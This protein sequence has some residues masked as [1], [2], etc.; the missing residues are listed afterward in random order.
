MRRL[1]WL[2][3]FS[4]AL[5]VLPLAQQRSIDDFFRQFSDE[6]VRMNPNLAVA[7]RYFTG[8]EQNQLEQQITPYT[9]G[10]TAKRRALAR[11]GIA[12]LTRF[13]RVRLT[14]VQRLSADLLKYQLQTYVGGERYDHF[15]FPLEQFDGA[16]ISLVTSLTVQHPM[17]A[18]RD[19]TNYVIRL[20]QVG[21]RMAEAIIDCRER[22]GGGLIPPRFI[23]Q[24]TITQMRRFVEVPVAENPFV[25][26]F[27]ERAMTISDL[28]SADRASLVAQA[29]QIVTTDVYPRWKEA[30]AFLE[31]LVPRSAD[32]AGLWRFEGG[33]EA[34]RY[35]LA[36]ST[37][38]NLTADQI[39]D[40][41]L[42]QV[43]R[44]EREMDALLQRLGRRD[45]S[46][47]ARVAQL[48]KDLGYPLTEDGRKQ[49]MADIDAMIAEAQ[50][51]SA[52]QFDRRPQ[53]PVIAQP[54]PRFREANAAAS[55]ASP[56]LDGSRPAIFQIP[57]RPERMT[58][59]GLRTLVHH[60]TVPG[61]HF[62]IALMVED[63]S[64]P[65]F[66]QARV[67][68]GIPAIT[69]GWALYA[70]RLAG[71][72]GW[73]ADDP[74]GLL[75]QMDGELFRARRLVVDTG[76]HAKRWTRQQAIDYGIEA[77]EVERYVVNPGQACAYMIGQLKILELRDRAKTTLKDRFNERAFH[78]AV[79]A[80]GTVPLELLEQEVNRYIRAA[81]N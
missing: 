19:A 65:R 5:V 76:L 71:E 12:E 38:T 16:N 78:N 2:S 31:S 80:P 77:S 47:K 48:K 69:E 72:S 66:R 41:G 44:L 34:Y 24:A 54:Y 39:H 37:S 7:A 3:V 57:L 40:I 56:P 42:K 55:Y 49:I 20:R 62:Q 25:S 22:A 9:S 27:N 1:L 28:S 81:S 33:A 73:Y 18:V 30:I 15:D 61:H 59:F 46:V 6:W 11:R 74:E 75:G 52:L 70:E 26:T 60:E 53:G 45:G 50:R 79:L 10:A 23:L 67:F 43:A 21:P 68:G 17:R 51:R 14:D 64:L 4:F 29:E 58:K 35:F 8:D 13:D 63:R 36:S 32:H